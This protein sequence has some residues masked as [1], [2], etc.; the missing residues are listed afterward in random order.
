MKE[1]CGTISFYLI[2]FTLA[3][4]DFHAFVSFIAIVIVIVDTRETL[5][6]DMVYTLCLYDVEIKINHKNV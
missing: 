2:S 1:I 6:I 4:I 3:L 5:P